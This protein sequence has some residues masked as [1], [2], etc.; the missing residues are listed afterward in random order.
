[1]SASLLKHREALRAQLEKLTADQKVQ[2][3]EQRRLIEQYASTARRSEQAASTVS[4]ML[5]TESNV[6]AA[7]LPESL[8]EAGK[9]IAMLRHES[10]SRSGQEASRLM[11]AVRLT[12][13]SER[14]AAL[15]LLRQQEENIE[16]LV[17]I[18]LIFF[19]SIKKNN[20]LSSHLFSLSWLRRSSIA[21]PLGRRLLRSSPSAVPRTRWPRSRKRRPNIW[22]LVQSPTL[23]LLLMST[24]SS[25]R[26]RTR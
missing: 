15:E 26:I 7:P 13:Q 8:E 25:W 19:Q 14:A 12:E 24:A 5:P 17:F 16:H 3:A 22:R 9:E 6:S 20:H 4:A 23:T 10:A 1:L 21:K 18:V 2:I 11:Q